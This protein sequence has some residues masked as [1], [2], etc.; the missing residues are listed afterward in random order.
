MTT[1]SGTIN[2]KSAPCD[3]LFLRMQKRDAGGLTAGVTSLWSL[4][5]SFRFMGMREGVMEAVMQWRTLPNPTPPPSSVP[6]SLLLL[7]LLLLHPPYYY[8][9]LY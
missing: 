1:D 9:P 5:K 6:S 8:T 3:S 2:V 7:S 4:G